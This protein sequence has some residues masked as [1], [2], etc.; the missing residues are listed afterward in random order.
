MKSPDWPPIHSVVL[1]YWKYRSNKLVQ[2]RMI[3]M[4]SH[5]LQFIFQLIYPF[6]VKL[7][8]VKNHWHKLCGLPANKLLRTPIIFF[9]QVRRSPVKALHVFQLCVHSAIISSLTLKPQRRRTWFRKA[10]HIYRRPDLGKSINADEAPALGASYQAA[11]VSNAFRVKTFHVKSASVYPI[12][13]SGRG[14][15]LTMLGTATGGPGRVAEG[16]G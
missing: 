16:G 7:P 5:L 4:N 13:V 12:E 1:I 15:W 6:E 14:V 11:A 8:Q 9:C 10:L 3:C 2:F